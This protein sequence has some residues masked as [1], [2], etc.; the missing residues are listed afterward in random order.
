MEAK[1][2]LKKMPSTA[3]NAIRRVAKVEFLSEIHRRAQSAFL[4]MQGTGL[5]I[6]DALIRTSLGR[7]TVVNSVEQVF[8]LFG[9]ADVCIDQQ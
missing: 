2:P 8:P 6:R 1:E 9:L 7:L 5:R 3:A 4:R